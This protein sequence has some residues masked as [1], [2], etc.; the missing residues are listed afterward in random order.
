MDRKKSMKSETLPGRNRTRSTM[1]LGSEKPTWNRMKRG[2][3]FN[4]AADR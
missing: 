3:F 2:K 1:F 4:Y